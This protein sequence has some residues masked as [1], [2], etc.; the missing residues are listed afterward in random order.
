MDKKDII[1]LTGSDEDNLE[2][3]QHERPSISSFVDLTEITADDASIQVPV[4]RLY[5]KFAPCAQSTD[6]SKF[7]VTNI[8]QIKPE[9]SNSLK[10]S[11]AISLAEESNGP[12]HKDPMR[13]DSNMEDPRPSVDQLN[14]PSLVM[15]NLQIVLEKHVLE[16]R[17]NH[18]WYTKVW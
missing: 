3:Q 16:M 1:D 6:L 5:E 13:H 17:A 8:S 4:Q 2:S 12:R 7:N 15:S 18:E 9:P 10:D 11:M 14:D